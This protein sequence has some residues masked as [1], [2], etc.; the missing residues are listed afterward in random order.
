M[1]NDNVLVT[2]KLFEGQHCETT[3]TG[4]LL[5]HQGITLSEPMMFGLSEGLGFIFLNL[6]SFNLPF[7]GGRTK[8]FEITQKLC[9]NLNLK[10]EAQETSSESKAWENLLGPL[11]DGFPVG[12]Q[13]DSY[14]LDYFSSK[15]HFAGHAI[16][17]FGIEGTH[18]LVMDTKQ[19]GGKHKIALSD[20]KKAR[21]AKGPMSAKARSWT[22]KATSKK[23][24]LNSAIQSAIRN[25]ANSYLNPEFKGMSYLGIEKLAKSLPKWLENAKNPEKDLTLQSLLMERAGTGGSIFRCFYRD[26]LQESSQIL[27]TKKLKDAHVSFREIAEDWSQVATLIGE[28]G[29]NLTSPPLM[30]ASKICEALAVKEKLAMQKLGDI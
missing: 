17:C 21:F 5:Y 1:K 13:L 4:N 3:A 20:L 10:L 2:Y 11:K 14:Y 27:D 29:K 15:V 25:N 26:F 30:K 22:I 24:S 23:V 7:V 16:A 8:P 18:V 6:K 12:L 19:Q 9:A 28:S